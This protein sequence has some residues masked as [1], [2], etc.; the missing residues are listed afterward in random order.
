MNHTIAMDVGQLTSRSEGVEGGK[1]VVN[2]G[3]ML[4]HAILPQYAE[5]ALA[6]GA[7][8]DVWECGVFRGDMS[9]DLWPVAHR[10][11]RELHLFDTFCGRP[12]KTAQDDGTSNGPF[13]DTSVAYVQARVPDA[14][15]H[16]GLI[17]STFTGMESHMI[18]FAY[19]DLDLFRST[20]AALTFIWPRVA[21]RGLVC[22]H[23]YA[24]RAWPGVKKAVD[25]LTRDGALPTGQRSFD[26]TDPSLLVLRK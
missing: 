18:A 8:G 22:V 17:P 4:P 19:V 7:I 1:R 24:T 25:A 15:L 5:I 2:V 11:G 3:H 16:P 9:V 6:A 21:A 14:I 10:Y 12:E 20:Y 26:A 13:S 23:D